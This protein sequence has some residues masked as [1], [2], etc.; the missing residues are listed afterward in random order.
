MKKKYKLHKKTMMKIQIFVILYHFIVLF[1]YICR[2][3]RYKSVEFGLF[4][5]NKILFVWFVSLFIFI[6]DF[7]YILHVI[8]STPKKRYR[9]N[10]RTPME[11][12]RANYLFFNLFFIW[13][14][15]FIFF[16]NFNLSFFWVIWN[17]MIWFS[18]FILS[19]RPFVVNIFWLCTLFGDK[20]VE[21]WKCPECWKY[22]LK[23]P[24]IYCSNC[25]NAKNLVFFNRFYC[26]D[27]GLE[28]KVE[29]F[30]FPNF[31]PHCGVPF[32]GRNKKINLWNLS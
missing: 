25:W 21:L 29:D 22:I 27:C 8:D 30:D 18:P 16:L 17:V 31:C 6:Y 24:I 4:M 14:I 13:P 3:Y 7:V 15:I 19:L 20:D 10:Y 12:L 2:L 23:K 28:P 9:R 1:Y 11:L 5:Q 32:K 26:K